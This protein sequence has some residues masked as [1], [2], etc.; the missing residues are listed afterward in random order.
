MLNDRPGSQDLYRLAE[1]LRMDVNDL[2]PIVEA[3]AL[4]DFAR[5]D[6][7]DVEITPAGKAFAEADISTRKRLFREAALAHVALLQQMERALAGKS[8]HTLPLEFFRDILETHFPEARGPAADRDGAELGPLW[9][10]PHV[11]LER[12]PSAAVSTRHPGA[13]ALMPRQSSRTLWAAPPWS[14][15]PARVPSLLTDLPVVLAGLA[16]FYG[17]V[18]LGRYWAG[19][20]NPQPEI[21]LTPAALPLYAL[22]SLARLGVAYGLSLAFTLV[23]GT[24]AAHNARAERVMIPLLDTLQSIPS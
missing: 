12:R 2:L 13:D 22:Y 11:R 10:H 14:A 16:L 24:V 23:Y 15:F 4:L 1:E 3:A 6:R 21:H 5:S 19:P 7:G 9:G 8:D 17:L 20:V 18:S